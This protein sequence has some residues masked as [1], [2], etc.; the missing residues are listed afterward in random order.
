MRN[1]G[2]SREGIAELS[3]SIQ[4][5]ER[6]AGMAWCAGSITRK[7][8]DAKCA[9]ETRG[10]W[11]P[12]VVSLSLSLSLPLVPGV[13]G[14]GEEKRVIHQESLSFSFAFQ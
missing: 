11:E 8:S 9:Q 2:Q 7:A 1:A 6:N 10:E 5:E 14:S 3:F 4:T 13:S 12:T